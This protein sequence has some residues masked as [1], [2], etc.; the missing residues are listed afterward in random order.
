[1]NISK[2]N[3]NVAI[4]RWSTILE[5]EKSLITNDA[6]S[7]QLRSA[8]CGFLAGDGSVQIRKEKTFYHYQLDFFP[9]DKEMLGIY[10]K[11]IGKVYHKLPSIKE[12]HN[13]FTARITSKT[14]ILDLL[15]YAQF[16]LKTWSLPDNLFRFRNAEKY[17]LKAFFSAEGTVN[18]KR[19]KIQSINDDG[20]KQ[21]S[22]LL[23]KFGIEHK[24]YF[25]IPK[26]INYNKVYIIMILKKDARKLFYN[27]IGFWHSKKNKLL[28]ESLDL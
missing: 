26:N 27:K 11:F 14:I 15:N 22:I 24:T 20:I 19:I 4:S 1:M 13:F 18:S 10:T 12:K 17:W 9:D 2:R 21:V 16:G 23:N 8:I 3:R 6:S 25:Y 28:K 7:M 5:K